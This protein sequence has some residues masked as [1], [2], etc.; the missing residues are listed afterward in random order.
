VFIGHLAA[1]NCSKR[2][3]HIV[4]P[5]RIEIQVMPSSVATMDTYQV[6]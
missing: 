3:S 4:G 2:C 5:F 6:R 1:P